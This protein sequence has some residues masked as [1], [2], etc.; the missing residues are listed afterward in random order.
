MLQEFLFF[1]RKKETIYDI[2]NDF[3]EIIDK[4]SLK[5]DKKDS[6]YV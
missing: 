2:I 6:L 5:S 3:Y 1:N 4:N